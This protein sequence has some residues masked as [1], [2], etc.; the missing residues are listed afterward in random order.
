[1]QKPFFF[2]L[3]E[4]GIT[5]IN[6]Y[7]VDRPI[8]ASFN[9]GSVIQAND[10]CNLVGTL[11]SQWPDNEHVSSGNNLYGSPAT[12]E[13]LTSSQDAAAASF[14]FAAAQA[15]NEMIIGQTRIVNCAMNVSLRYRY[16]QDVD[17]CGPSYLVFG[18]L[19]CD[20][21]SIPIVYIYPMSIDAMH[22]LDGLLYRNSLTAQKNP[23]FYQ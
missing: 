23:S 17:L 14:A 18:Q 19:G 8:S 21:H 7:I 15:S 3:I 13:S 1:M 2:Q 4:N 12:I 16:I 10:N 9:V 6:I 5:P 11:G 20:S 22:P